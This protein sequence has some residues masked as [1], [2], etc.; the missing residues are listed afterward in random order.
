VVA[1]IIS[2]LKRLLR[3]AV[4]SHQY[5]NNIGRFYLHGLQIRTSGGVKFAI[6]AHL[7]KLA[8]IIV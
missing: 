3:L 1:R 6:M 2:C 8:T 5:G 4:K 7:T